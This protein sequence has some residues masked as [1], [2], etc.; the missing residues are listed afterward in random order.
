MAKQFINRLPEDHS[1]TMSIFNDLREEKSGQCLLSAISLSQV[2][3]E[4]VQ[5]MLNEMCKE[6]MIQ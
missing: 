1:I 6:Y 3:L 2:R 5:E 4:L